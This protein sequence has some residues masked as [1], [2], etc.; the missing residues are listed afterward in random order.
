M[1]DFGLSRKF[2]SNN[3][4][5]KYDIVTSQGSNLKSL[6]GTPLYIAPE[7]LKAKYD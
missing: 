1:I 7:V 4:S 3:E 6:V 5:N 2:Y